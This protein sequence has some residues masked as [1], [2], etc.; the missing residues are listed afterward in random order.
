MAGQG[1]LH[2]VV[3]AMKKVEDSIYSIFNDFN[4]ERL[5]SY[6]YLQCK[7]YVF[8]IVVLKLNFLNISLHEN[9]NFKSC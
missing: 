3:V 6:F 1:Q 2:A 4:N 9:I 5:F 8:K 7:L